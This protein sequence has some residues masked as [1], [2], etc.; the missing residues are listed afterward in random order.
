MSLFFKH[1]IIPIVSRVNIRISSGNRIIDFL[2]WIH[3]CSQWVTCFN[4]LIVQLH[5]CYRICQI[6]HTCRGC[7][8]LFITDIQSGF[9]FNTFFR[10][11]QNNTICS[12]R[13]IKGC[14]C[15]I[16]HNIKTGNVIWLDFWQIWRRYLIIIQQYQWIF[17]ITECCYT[18]NEEFC[19][20]LPRFS[21]S[22]ISNQAGNTTCQRCCQVTTGNL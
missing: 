8:R 4:G 10:C 6:N 13:T 14:C 22:L 1:N 7:D 18:A 3:G 12:T 21:T 20:V 15:S 16:F 19:I 9:S 17:F 5:I 2:M 11:N